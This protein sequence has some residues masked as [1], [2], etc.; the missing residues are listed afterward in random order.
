VVSYLLWLIGG[1]FTGAHHL[2]L[3]RARAALLCSLSVG[4]FGLEW[5]VDAFRIP[6]YV[7]AL[8]AAESEVAAAQHAA[9][10]KDWEAPP[11]SMPTSASAA[12]AAADDISAAPE[13]STR[14]SAVRSSA[15]RAPAMDD[16]GSASA[17]GSASG[18]A[19]GAASADAASVAPPSTPLLA[20]TDA[21]GA[22]AAAQASASSSTSSSS[23]GAAAQLG[24]VRGAWR[25]LRLLVWRVCVGLWLSHVVRL[26][27]APDDRAP[28][29]TL[30][31][32]CTALATV[33]LTSP[34][35][36]GAPA[37]LAPSRIPPHVYGAVGFGC[38]LDRA[39]GGVWA[40]LC[41]VGATT[42]PAWRAPPPRATPRRSRVEGA[43]VLVLI[44]LFWLALIAEGLRRLTVLAQRTDHR[45]T[46]TFPAPSRPIPCT[47]L[48]CPGP[49][50]PTLLPTSPTLHRAS[51][52]H[53]AGPC[54]VAGAV[55]GRRP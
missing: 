29:A 54:H 42:L 37:Q 30:L 52:R 53:T 34:P 14:L 51:R 50:T 24:C 43:I 48:A 46:L 19:V 9:L 26:L 23:E 10:R 22:L 38:L 39:G 25:T 41:A 33:S 4:G 36:P 12:A 6:I 31:R 27:L 5:L 1:F 35:P 16:G 13:A 47:R 21:A 18:A 44:S 45:S 17:D 55:D 49:S 8:A 7:R 3:G 11:S 20:Q 2:Y 15:A 28:A 32:A 40:L